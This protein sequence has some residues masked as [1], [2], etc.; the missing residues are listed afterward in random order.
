MHTTSSVQ[1][2]DL[3]PVRSRISWSAIVAGSVLALSLYFLLALLGSAIGLSVSDKVS[4]RTLNSGAAV[5]AIVVTAVCLFFGGYVA[6]QLTTGE[7]KIEGGLY[8]IFVWATVFA[9]LLWLMASG[10]KMGFNAVVGVA[11]AGGAVDAR[12]VDWEAAARQAGVPPERIEEWK[13]KANAA[14]AARPAAEDPANQQAAADAATRATWYAF[15]GAWVS[16]MAAAGGGYLG[17]G[18]TLRLFAMSAG[19]E[20]TGRPAIIQA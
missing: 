20:P 11:T 14:P 5:Y 16:M 19:R 15:F 2:E 7:N 9:M 6:S 12:P 3:V 4:G 8:G 18:P 10:V 1:A 13:Q 17:S